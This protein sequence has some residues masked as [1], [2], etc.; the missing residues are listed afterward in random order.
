MSKYKDVVFQDYEDVW[1]DH[2]DVWYRGVTLD[3][4]K[5]FILVN[6]RLADSARI[7]VKPLLSGAVSAYSC[8][9]GIIEVKP[10]E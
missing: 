1:Q 6:P 5:G 3:A 10:H 9:K 8:L 2:E 4:L 7:I